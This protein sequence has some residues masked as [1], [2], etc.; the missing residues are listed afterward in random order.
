LILAVGGILSP[1]DPNF[2]RD[3]RG[4][5]SRRLLAFDIRRLLAAGQQV[6]CDA[7]RVVIGAAM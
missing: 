4:E 6:E 7:P 5:H 2:D 1:G 3:Y